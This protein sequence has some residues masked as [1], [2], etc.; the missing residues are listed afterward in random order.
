MSPLAS[1][2]SVPPPVV[3]FERPALRAAASDRNAETTQLARSNDDARILCVALALQAFSTQLQRAGAV[4]LDPERD[5]AAA[6]TERGLEAGAVERGLDRDY[7]HAA[8]AR[9]SA[10]GV[11]PMSKSTSSATTA[12]TSL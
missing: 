7:P 4:V 2:S 10:R 8:A 11:S 9:V 1:N 3:E 5:P 6:V 12:P